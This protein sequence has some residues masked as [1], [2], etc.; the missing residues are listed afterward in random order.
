MFKNYLKVI[1]FIA[2]FSIPLFSF[3]PK[4]SNYDTD[5]PTVQKFDG[6]IN[7]SKNEK[8]DK[9]PIGEVI[10]KV[11][12]QF[13]GAM[14]LGHTLEGEKEVCRV[15]FQGLDC[16]T[17]FENSLDLARLIKKGNTSFN[18]YVKELTFTRYRNGV[19]TDYTSRLH[20]T[21]D[22]INDNIR[23]GTIKDITQDLGGKEI[24]FSLS[25]MSKNYDKYQ[26]LKD[27]PNLIPAIQQAEKLINS[28]SYYFI[29]A[30]KIESI[31]Q[32]LQTGDIIGIVIDNNGLDYSHTGLIIKSKD[33]VAHFVHASSTINKVVKDDAIS[34]YV[35]QKSAKGITIL[36]PL[37]PFTK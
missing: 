6:I 31:E 9:L 36:R 7:L 11:A 13:L 14:Y 12:E 32:K 37:E 10:G 27:N 17:F 19:I 18:D 26:Q 28:R 33:G 24:K 15:T 20:Y 34:K 16:V 8:W 2:I 22:W 23:K 21:A 29:P 5:N 4:E 25:F 30:D 3:L 1:I 35:K